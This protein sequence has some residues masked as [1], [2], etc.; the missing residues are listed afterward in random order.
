MDLQ[1]IILLLPVIFMIHDFEELIFFKKWINDNEFELTRRF[2]KLSKKLLPHFKNMSTAS[3]CVGVA[4]EF[5]LISTISVFAVINERYEFWYGIFIGFFIHILIHI[6]QW[7]IYRKYTPSII[8]SF[9]V[10]PYCF[11]ALNEINELK[12]MQLN[13]KI[14]WGIFGLLIVLLN[15]LLVHKIITKFEEFLKRK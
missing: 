12:I 13:E 1:T 6:I 9:L 2:P 4:E 3:F 15:L 14:I 11:Y 8:T 7:L 5:L 10:L